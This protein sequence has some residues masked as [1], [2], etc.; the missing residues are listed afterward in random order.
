MNSAASSIYI[1]GIW[2]S[3]NPLIAALGEDP[4][5]L[6]R[7]YNKTA[8]NKKGGA[9]ATKAAEEGGGGGAKKRG[10]VRRMSEPDDPEEHT[11]YTEVR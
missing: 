11:T 2:S 5:L 1:Q 10:R 3:K 8:S 7:G 6:Q 4:T 9:A